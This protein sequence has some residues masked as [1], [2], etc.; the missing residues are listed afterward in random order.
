VKNFDNAINDKDNEENEEG[1]SE[2]LLRQSPVKFTRERRRGGNLGRRR[3][4]FGRTAEAMKS[5]DKTHRIPNR[6]TTIANVS[7]KL[8]PPFLSGLPRKENRK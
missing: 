1:F 8:N 2:A 5:V 7:H 3:K 4:R 6:F